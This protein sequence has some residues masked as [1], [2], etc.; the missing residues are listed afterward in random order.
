MSP[1]IKAG[2][3]TFKNDSHVVQWVKFQLKNGTRE[4]RLLSKVRS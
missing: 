4:S 1:F 3:Q 2:I